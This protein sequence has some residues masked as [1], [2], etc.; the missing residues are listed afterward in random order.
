MFALGLAGSRTGSSYCC[1]NHLGMSLGS[2]NLLGSYDILTIV[3]LLACGDT[4]LGT[5]RSLCLAY[6]NLVCVGT[7]D[8]THET[9]GVTVLV[10]FVVIR[11]T[12]CGNCYFRSAHFTVTYDA[13]SY[14]VVLARLGTVG[15]N[16]IFLYRACGEMIGLGNRILRDD[17]LTA[18]RA[19]YS[20]SEAFLGTG[21][22]LS[23][24]GNLGVSYGDNLF[25][26]LE[27]LAAIGAL[28]ALGQADLGA[29]RCFCLAYCLHVS[30]QAFG[31]VR[32]AASGEHRYTA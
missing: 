13:V 10:K 22:K 32:A 9:T 12:L 6:R 14:L 7:V 1:V 25:L 20:V 21:R 3:A 2:D 5:S 30:V 26:L 24:Y 11:V 18:Y 8:V 17:D 23:V 29:G 31:I 15:S 16:L 19:N 27:N 4:I 28:L